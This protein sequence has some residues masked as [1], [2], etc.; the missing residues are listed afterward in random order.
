MWLAV[1]G[2]SVLLETG[3]SRVVNTKLACL[4]SSSRGRGRSYSP[5]AT[6]STKRRNAERGENGGIPQKVWAHEQIVWC[7]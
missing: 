3:T 7:L 6:T 5:L 4:R 1:Y 2:I